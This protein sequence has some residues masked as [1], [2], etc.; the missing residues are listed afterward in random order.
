MYYTAFN[1]RSQRLHSN[2]LDILEDTDDKTFK[3]I[4]GIDTCQGINLLLF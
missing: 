3:Y 1:F 4:G 2:I